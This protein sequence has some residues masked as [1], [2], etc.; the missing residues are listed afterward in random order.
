MTHK[1]DELFAAEQLVHQLVALL[2]I[3]VGHESVVLLARGKKSDD[4][5]V[6]TAK[7]GFIAA[8][9]RRNECAAS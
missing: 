7:E 9:R 6:D 4:V 2:R 3:G 8:Q 1:L 5:D